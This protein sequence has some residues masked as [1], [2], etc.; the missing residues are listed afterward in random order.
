M[1]RRKDSH[2]FSLLTFLF[3]YWLA[4]LINA[5]FDVFLEGPVGGIWFWCVYGTGIGAVWIYKN[6]P[7]AIEEKKEPEAA[8]T[9]QKRRNRKVVE[10]LGICAS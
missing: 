6:C 9:R 3:V 5:S 7:E 10:A 8:P 1:W 4:Y 2:W